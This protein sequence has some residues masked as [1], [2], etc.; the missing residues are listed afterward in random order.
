[1]AKSRF[2]RPIVYAGAA[3][4]VTGILSGLVAA[5][6]ASTRAERDNRWDNYLLAENRMTDAAILLRM[7]A[8][9]DVVVRVQGALIAITE[10][11]G[12][13]VPNDIRTLVDNELANT[14]ATGDNSVYNEVQRRIGEYQN[15]TVRAVGVELRRELEMLTL[16]DNSLRLLTIL[17]GLAGTI[18]GALREAPE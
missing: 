13:D 7:G 3:V 18:A 1:M 14:L 8:V 9:R 16:L 10:A 15:T 2:K 17:C 12:T 6:V 4:A 11:A 5:R